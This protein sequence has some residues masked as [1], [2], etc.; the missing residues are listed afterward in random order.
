MVVKL[1]QSLSNYTLDI[2]D[3]LFDNDGMRM[4]S[5]IFM[6]INDTKRRI[7]LDLK[8]E[9]ILFRPDSSINEVSFKCYSFI[10]D[11]QGF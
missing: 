5:C 8:N 3:Y 7:I 9:S 6:L 1:I 4:V 10:H 11:V 2:L